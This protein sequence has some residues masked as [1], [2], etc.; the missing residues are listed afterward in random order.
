MSSPKQQTIELDILQEIRSDMREFKHQ[1]QNQLDEVFHLIEGLTAEVYSLKDQVRILSASSISYMRE[2]SEQNHDTS[3][4][5]SPARNPDTIMSSAC[6]NEEFE[7]QEV[8]AITEGM[9]VYL[10]A[11]GEKSILCN[12]G[13]L[14]PFHSHKIYPRI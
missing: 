9:V 11:L 5:L 13:Y 14:C 6:I 1:T 7:M 2:N 4:T 3:R 8:L 12:M 10:V